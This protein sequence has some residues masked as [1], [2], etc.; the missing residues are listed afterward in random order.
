VATHKSRL[1][2][3]SLYE[4]KYRGIPIDYD[5]RLIYLYDKLKINNKVENEILEKRVQ[6]LT[7]L[8]FNDI[9]IVL[10]EIPEGAPRPR[11]RII[12][13]SNFM[14]EAIANPNFVHV[15]SI[16]AHEDSVFMSRLLAQD[17]ISL[18][19]LICTPCEITINT[20]S[21][22]PSYFNRV[23]TFLA[24]LGL[25]R[26]IAKPDWDNIEKK[27]SDMFNHNIWLDDTLV[28]DGH[29]HKYYSILPRLEIDLRYLNMVYNRYQYNSIINRSDYK[30]EYQLKYFGG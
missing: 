15:Y 23:D 19:N 6:M 12:N 5:D 24:E 26:P 9:K 11:F 1:V 25:H 7:S 10:F 8:Y 16:N 30:E 14:N 28:V 3:S 17:L 22:T 27:Y 29:I 4:D 2:K 18:Q 21:P 20:Y 13:R